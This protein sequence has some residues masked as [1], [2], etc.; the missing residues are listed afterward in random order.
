MAAPTPRRVNVDS[1]KS[2]L[3][4]PSLTSYY[5][6]NIQP[7][8]TG[9]LN[10]RLN[11]WGVSL[12]TQN[13]TDYISLACAETSLPGSSLT[14]IDIDNDYHGVSE[15]HAYRRI[16]DDRIDFTFYVNVNRNVEYY[17][18][19]FFEAWIGYIVNEQYRDP[20]PVNKPNYNYRINYPRKNKDG[21]G[22]YYANGLSVTKF[23]RDYDGK[24]LRYNFENAFPISINSMPVSYDQ[25]NLLK[26]SV[27]F[28]YSRYWIDAAIGSGISPVSQNSQFDV[29]EPGLFGQT[30]FNLNQN[31]L[32]TAN[33][34]SPYSSL[35]NLGSLYA[36]VEPYQKDLAG[37]GINPYKS[38]ET[39]VGTNGGGRNP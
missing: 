29:D 11:E 7:P 13:N 38:T 16:Y 20:L 5:L 8:V 14:T 34:F 28:S 2:K 1:I 25:S 17:V 36:N 9:F 32:S 35:N 15:K 33:K 23:E 10:D 30:G 3:L 22:G 27:S 18:I 12:N 24:S 39:Q 37:I 31:S 6:V 19:K 26:C 4:R 21:N